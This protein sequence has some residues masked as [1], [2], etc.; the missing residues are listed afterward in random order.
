MHA[1]LFTRMSHATSPPPVRCGSLVRRRRRRR[2]RGSQ[3]GVADAVR[4]VGGRGHGLE[5]RQERVVVQAVHL[6][7]GVGRRR[8]RRRRRAGH[9]EDVVGRRGAG[10]RRSV[11]QRLR[12]VGVAPAVVP[13]AG[14]ACGTVVHRQKKTQLIVIGSCRLWRWRCLG[15]QGRWPARKVVMGKVRLG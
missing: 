5:A 9:A 8:R 1:A 11:S 10:L 15:N 6:L 7:A 13:V 4:P 12:P 14:H 3:F 2:R